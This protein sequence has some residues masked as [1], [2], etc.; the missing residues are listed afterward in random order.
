MIKYITHITLPSKRTVTGLPLCLKGTALTARSEGMRFVQEQLIHPPKKNV[1][2]NV[3]W[4][5]I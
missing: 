5:Y 4:M 2:K 1:S 3:K